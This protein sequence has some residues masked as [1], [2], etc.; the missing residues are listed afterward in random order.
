MLALPF[1][2]LAL[3]LAQQ[4]TPPRKL[5]EGSLQNDTFLPSSKPAYDKLSA[6]DAAF[7]NS[8]TPNAPLEAFEL[9]RQAL[10]DAEPGA[11]VARLPAGA[12]PD[13]D[14]S[15]ERRAED[16]AWAV[17]RR[18]RALN[19]EQ[20]RAWR[21]RFDEL[22]RTAFAQSGLARAELV[23][24][25][26]E[27]VGTHGAAQAALAL[28]DR[29]LEAGFDVEARTWLERAAWHGSSAELESALAKRRALLGGD[30]T[31][32]EDPELAA[33]DRAQKLRFV[34]A[35]ALAP[36]EP[37]YA[38][39]LRAGVAFDERGIAWVQG[40][41]L[42]ARIDTRAASGAARSVFTP[43]ELVTPHGLSFLP[44]FGEPALPWTL[45][46]AADA[47][48][49]VLVL[50][51]AREDRGNALACFDVRDVPALR[52]AYSD[53]GFV[54]RDALRGDASAKLEPGL[55]EFQPGALLVD[56][57]V[58][59]QTRRY[60]PDER[61]RGRVDE[62]RGEAAVWAFDARTG[63][64]R[65]RRTLASGA[66]ARGL[67]RERVGD[68][69]GI[70]VPAPPLLRAGTRVLAATELGALALVDL[71]DGRLA[72]SLLGA[73]QPEGDARPARL[74]AAARAESLWQP[75]DAGGLVYTVRNTPDVDAQGILRLAP[76]QPSTPLL[77]EAARAELV[78]G[79]ARSAK[80]SRWS[81]WNPR[82]GAVWN[83]VGWTP[84]PAGSALCGA[85]RALVACAGELWLL[86]LERE[87]AVIA[88][89]PAPEHGLD[90]GATLA[91]HAGRAWLVGL[92]HISVF[93]LE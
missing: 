18:V 36:V 12:R 24:I 19:P 21:A 83:S 45:A 13:P 92:D 80:D 82:T 73:R 35:H 26:R 64:V 90:A 66:D 55:F 59:C 37:A 17:M 89:A 39:G 33:L 65:W 1:V 70:S 88:R 63:A 25:E 51:R 69:R 41:E 30:A 81:A 42:V 14:A 76:R 31:D 44:A 93:A 5:A 46:P 48:S 60:M 61:G 68:P 23:R 38:R 6:G 74:C 56:G 78:L 8:A 50:G 28:C 79:S 84:E 43:S 91:V 7:A 57:S 72:W 87:L 9:W 53:S 15:A 20:S 54:G 40:A 86:D 27:L 85:R 47:A 52:W 22:A 3:A 34:E 67:A 58:I 71:A 2:A 4:V 10:V 11:T 16:V 29:A 77:I 75:S 32:A 62:S 49:L